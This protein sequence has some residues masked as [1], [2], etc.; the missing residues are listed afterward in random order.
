MSVDRDAWRQDQKVNMAVA[1]NPFWRFSHWK[2]GRSGTAE[3]SGGP[4]Q[5]IENIKGRCKEGRTMGKT[6][7]T[8]TMGIIGVV[9]ATPMLLNATRA[10]AAPKR[11][12]P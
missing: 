7:F 2:Q 5:S 6:R 10:F 3:L 1:G 9:L 8:C 11:Q 4:G 12:S